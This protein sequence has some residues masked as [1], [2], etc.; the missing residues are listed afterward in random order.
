MRL[1]TYNEI[2]PHPRTMS[3]ARISTGGIGDGRRSGEIR[4]YSEVLSDPRTM[5]IICDFTEPVLVQ[6][7]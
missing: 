4:T 2:K 5:S 3:I 6:V 1:L 7:E